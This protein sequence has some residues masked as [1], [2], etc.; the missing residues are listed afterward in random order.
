MSPFLWIF[1]LAANWKLCMGGNCCRRS[2]GASNVFI[3]NFAVKYTNLTK[4]RL[5][6][7]WIDSL[8][9]LYMYE[10]MCN[11][12]TNH[13]CSSRFRQKRETYQMQAG[14][15]WQLINILEINITFVQSHHTIGMIILPIT[16]V[17]SR[18]Q[19]AVAGGVHCA[20]VNTRLSAWSLSPPRTAALQHTSCSLHAA[21]P[22]PCS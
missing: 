2:A 6:D 1:K 13:K 20:R 19:A 7:T 18:Y 16:G 22:P 10:D 11:G 4:T 14:S 21:H 8:P 9:T 12:N 15:H 5:T 17:V 3:A